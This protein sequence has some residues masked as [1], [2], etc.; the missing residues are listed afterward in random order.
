MA[1]LGL[2]RAVLV[3]LMMV[4]AGWGLGDG[5]VSFIEGKKRSIPGLARVFTSLAFGL[6]VIGQ[7]VF[8]FGC[9]GD[10]YQPHYAWGFMLLL[11]MFPVMRLRKKFLPLD[12]KVNFA[13]TETLVIALTLFSLFIWFWALLSFITGSDVISDHYQFVNVCINLKHFGHKL[14]LPLGMDNFSTYNPALVH[15]LFLLAT[16]LSDVRAANLIFWLTHVLVIAAI[17]I[18]ARDFFSRFAGFIAVAIYFGFSVLLNFSLDVNNYVGLT[19]FMLFSMY[20]VFL[21]RK[22]DS[23]QYLVLAGILAGVMLSTKYYGIALMPALCVPLLLNSS[24]KVHLR[25]KA[26]VLFCMVAL[27]VYLP[28]II[29]NVKEFGVPIYPMMAHIEDITRWRLIRAEQ[30]LDPY[31]VFSDHGYFW[32]KFFYYLSM[33]IPFEPSYWV[34]GLTPVFLIGLPCSFYYLFKA[35]GDKWRDINIL[36]LTSLLAFFL[37]EISSWPFAFYKTAIF[38]GSIYAISLAALMTLLSKKGKQ[39]MVMIVLLVAVISTFVGA[40]HIRK[41]LYMPLVM[42]EEY[43][44]SPLV[45]Y[46]NKNLEK[47]ASL[48]NEDAGSSY[49]IRP[50]IKNISARYYC[51]PYN[52]PREEKLIRSQRIKYYVFDPKERENTL[53]YL[54]HMLEVL[55]NLHA[56]DRAAAFDRQ[57][58]SYN[59]RTDQQE[60]FLNKNGKIVKEFPDGTRIYR[61]RF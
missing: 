21:F 9:A 34:F 27:I 32:P 6:G 1:V 51:L 38:A 29:Y 22:T 30:L 16:I 53:P 5:I 23:N 26:A 44:W 43:Y 58:R 33:F 42:N 56:F 39:W 3:F 17:Y 28:W 55:N 14:T 52:W 7:I 18:F 45:E 25:I 40:H 20:Y 41:L 4:M 15:M 24:Q 19:S 2:L 13:K 61:L 12:I 8:M 50:D 37:V 31:V 36:F 11:L 59:Q 47:N 10:F 49:Y 48:A 35:R 54:K 57:I 46:I 60:V